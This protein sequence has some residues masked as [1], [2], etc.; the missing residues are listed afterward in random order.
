MPIAADSLY[1]AS[2]IREAISSAQPKEKL[3]PEPPWPYEWKIRLDLD[4]VS[5]FSDSCLLGSLS[6][7]MFS[8]LPGRKP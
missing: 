4:P 7:R 2:S 1:S 5:S 3:H 6:T 8:C